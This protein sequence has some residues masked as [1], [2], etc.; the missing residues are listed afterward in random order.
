MEISGEVFSYDREWLVS[1][2]TTSIE[3]G[4][5]VTSASMRQPLGAGPISCASFQ[6]FSELIVECAFDS[7]D[8]KLCVPRQMA[9]VLGK[10][11]AETTS[12]FDEFLDPGWKERGV[13]PLEIKALCER[14]GRAYYF[15]SGRRMLGSYDQP[16]GLAVSKASR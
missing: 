6:P 16:R 14:Q 2:M 1:E 8:D 12:W 15:L 11:L 3:N 9:A 4:E 7:H 10:S 13:T 5:A